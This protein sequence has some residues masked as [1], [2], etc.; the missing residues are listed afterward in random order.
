MFAVKEEF[1]L[2]LATHTYLQIWTH[3]HTLKPN[4]HK[5]LI[6]SISV[7]ILSERQNISFTLALVAV[8]G[9]LT[10]FM[11]HIFKTDKLIK[12]L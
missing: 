12:L 9:I 11:L 10:Y 1:L 6:Y 8:L 7:S 2:T 3:G 4:S 5:R